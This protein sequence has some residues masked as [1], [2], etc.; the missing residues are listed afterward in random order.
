[1]A[2]AIIR[3][4]ERLAMLRVSLPLALSLFSAGRPMAAASMAFSVREPGSGGPPAAETAPPA[5]Q[6][7]YGLPPAP[8]SPPPSFAV[9]DPEPHAPNFTFTPL[10]GQVG[11]HGGLG[12]DMTLGIGYAAIGFRRAASEEFCLFCADAESESQSAFLA[13]VRLPLPAGSLSART[14]F[15]AVK[16]V[17][18]ENF[19]SDGSF[20]SEP[21]YDLRTFEGMGVPLQFD[22]QAGGRFVGF[23]LSVGGV[24]DRDGGAVDAMIGMPFGY[25]H[26]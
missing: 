23:C 18:K 1:M 16:R 20:F 3:G 9:E 14:G 2:L 12:F 11:A 7:R 17:R 26:P 25:L 5:D 10:L 8:I 21:R 6:S 19:V 24:F 15:A 22:L 4:N 13:G